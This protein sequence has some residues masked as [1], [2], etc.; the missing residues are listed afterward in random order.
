MS[1]DKI[2]LDLCGGTGAWSKPY[3]DAGYDVINVT[4][5]MF[6]IMKTEIT[7]EYVHFH[8]EPPR[9]PLPIKLENVYGILAAPPCTM[10]SKARTTAKT[11]RDFRS[12]MATVIQCLGIIWECRYRKKLK[13]WA[14][15]NPNGLLRQFLG[16]PPLTFQPYDFGDPFSKSTDI[17][18]YFKMPKKNRLK[19]DRSQYSLF[20]F[21]KYRKRGMRCNFPGLTSIGKKGDPRRSETFPGFANAFFEANR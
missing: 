7:G 10:F 9:H 2:I 6:D 4:L 21:K 3:A 16:T 17:W 19:F 13:F 15:E 20:T 12:G 11:P 14:L 18:G 5:P 1:K 8:R